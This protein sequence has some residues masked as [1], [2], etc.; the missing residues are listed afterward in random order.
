MICELFQGATH[1][2]FSFEKNDIRMPFWTGT[3]EETTS[4][5][6]DHL[7]DGFVFAQSSEGH[8]CEL[9]RGRGASSSGYQGPWGA[10]AMVEEMCGTG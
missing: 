4:V 7:L 3:Q 2:S 6:G 1:G 5:L 9:H 8:G 10:G